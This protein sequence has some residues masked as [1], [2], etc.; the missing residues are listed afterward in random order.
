MINLEAF[1]V[2]LGRRIRTARIRQN[3]TQKQLGDLLLLNRTSITNIEKG[4]QKI[5][6]HML[7]EIADKLNISVDELISNQY[8][9]NN[10]NKFSHLLNENKSPE[11]L[12]FLESVLNKA[13]KK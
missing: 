4:K 6:A 10:T 2:E 1:Y 8:R 11:E 9:N 13:K 5:L 3:L 7:I 12:D